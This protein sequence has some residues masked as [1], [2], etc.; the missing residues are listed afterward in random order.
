MAGRPAS[1]AAP[2]RFPSRSSPRTAPHPTRSLPRSRCSIPATTRPYRRCT[3]GYPDGSPLTPTT[4]RTRCC[5]PATCR[6]RADT[7]PLS[8]ASSCG[9]PRRLAFGRSRCS[10]RPEW[11][12][13]RPS[14]WPWPGPPRRVSPSSASHWAATPVTTSP[15]SPRPSPWPTSPTIWPSSPR[16]AITMPNGRSGRPRS[17]AW[18]RSARSTRETGKSAGPGSATTDGGWMCTRQASGSSAPICRPPGNCR[19]TRS[20]GPWTATPTG[21]GRR[22]PRRKSPP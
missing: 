20:R 11:A 13:T 5:R 19:A 21:A 15:R 17:S 4:S 7:A 9:W 16:L 10:T 1:R 2:S 14:P 6:P 3:R 18:S 12:M 8:T 22:S